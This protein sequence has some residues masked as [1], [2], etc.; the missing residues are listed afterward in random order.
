LKRAREGVELPYEIWS[1][2]ARRTILDIGFQALDRL[3]PARAKEIGDLMHRAAAAA[4]LTEED[5]L[6]VRRDVYNTA[7]WHLLADDRLGEPQ[8]KLLDT[9]RDGLGISDDSTS[10]ESA[11]AEAFQK[12]R[13]VTRDELPRTQCP[14]PLQFGEYCVHTTRGKAGGNDV[15]IGITNRRFILGGKKLRDVELMN[16]DDLEVDVDRNRVLVRMAKPM[17]PI[18]LEVD[19]AI[20]TAALLDLAATIDERP[21]SFA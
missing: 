2:A 12:L 11:A 17:K 20:Y 9:L 14:F 13:G 8:S 5:D 18:E 15:V 1:P 10:P 21:R 16:I 6:A 7:A 3:K 4:G 19:D